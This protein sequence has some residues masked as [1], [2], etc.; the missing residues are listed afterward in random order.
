MDE[1]LAFID[2]IG[3]KTDG[4]FIYRLDFT[5]DKEIVWGD[6]FNVTPSAIIPDLQP[7]ENTISKSCKVDMPHE[8]ILAKKNYC[9]S[10]Q[11]CIDGIIPLCFAEIDSKTIEYEDKPFFLTFGETFDSVSLKLNSLGFEMYDITE[12]DPTDYSAM[13]DLLSDND[14]DDNNF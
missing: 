3:K 7:D 12:V 2:F 9:F 1:Y 5:V 11:D 6:Y 8:L 14:I 13:D 4:S 10:M